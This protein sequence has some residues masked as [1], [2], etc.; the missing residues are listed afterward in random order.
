MVKR[1][2]NKNQG[3]KNIKF[4]CY[5]YQD[6]LNYN[7]ILHTT[8]EC[9]RLGY[10][11]IWLKD[12]YI[13]WIE[14]YMGSPSSRGNK[15]LQGNSRYLCADTRLQAYRELCEKR[16]ML[17]CWT[18][19]SSLAHL[20]AKIRLG[21]T[22]VNIYRWP[23]IVAKMAST[24]DNICNGR[25]ELGL[26]AGWYQNEARAYGIPFPSGP[27]RVEM[28]KESVIILKKIF[29][30]DGMSNESLNNNSRPTFRGKYYRISH[31]ECNP[32]PIQTPHMPIWI[33]GGGKK[34]LKIVAKYADG[35]VYGLCSFEEYVK[36]TSYLR[37]C[38]SNNSFS[39]LNKINEIDNV[40]PKCYGDIVRAW[41]AILLLGKD[42]Y[43][44]EKRKD[45]LLNR[46][47][48]W[49]NSNMLIIGTPDTILKEICRYLKIGVTYFALHFVDLPDTNSLKLFAKYIISNIKNG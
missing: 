20:T 10:D 15:S 41:H 27:R 34:T 25:L 13:P 5:I 9:E 35:W 3:N 16:A 2:T 21:A 24:L 1:S 37:Y 19:L 32:K 17:E 7:D 31:V 36:K 22:L 8:L 23:S 39:D 4:G 6:G 29:Q 30:S 49:I 40:H 26:S 44:V 14:E 28:L 18:V 45:E 43:E 11:S 47:G 48:R 46:K 12:N 33:G 38:C 42:E